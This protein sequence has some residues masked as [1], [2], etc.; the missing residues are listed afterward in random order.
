MEAPQGMGRAGRS[1]EDAAG[2]LARA[3]AT[4]TL[5][6]Q[7]EALQG[8]REGAAPDGRA[9][10]AAAGCG[11]AGPCGREGPLARDDRDPLGRPLPRT[12]ED[13]GPDRNMVPGEA[14]IERARRASSTTMRSR[15]GEPG[16]RRSSSITSSACC[17]GSTDAG[18][19]GPLLSYRLGNPAAP[20]ARQRA[21]TAY[22]AA[23]GCTT[24]PT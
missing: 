2:A 21:S 23:A 9:D 13:Y 12:G 18:R 15:S 16:R 1:M 7:N 19:G 6:S 10:D 20:S 11:P 5:Q 3:T 22:S 14:A 24:R 8:L 4:R 17:A